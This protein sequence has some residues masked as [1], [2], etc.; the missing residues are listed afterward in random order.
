[1]ERFPSAGPPVEASVSMKREGTT[2]V[3]SKKQGSGNCAKS[4]LLSAVVWS[5]QFAVREKLIILIS[6][7]HVNCLGYDPYT[8]HEEA[9]SEVTRANTS[10]VPINTICIGPTLPGDESWM[11]ALA[12]RNRGSYVRIV[13]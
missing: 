4:A 12:A 2:W 9:L 11:R 8:Y 7:G 5:N 1:M 6:S 3:Q 13:D 10:R